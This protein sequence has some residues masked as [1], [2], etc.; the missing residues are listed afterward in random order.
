MD[1]IAD[2]LVPVGRVLDG[3]ERRALRVGD[4]VARLGPDAR[5]TLIGPG[6][7]GAIAKIRKGL[8]LVITWTRL[9][10]VEVYL[11]ETGLPADAGEND[12]RPYL[13]LDPEDVFAHRS[14]ARR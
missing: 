4:Q 11:V 1:E 13:L 2:F 7:F 10:Q 8:E 14:R 9:H 3:P 5:D 12:C 6:Q